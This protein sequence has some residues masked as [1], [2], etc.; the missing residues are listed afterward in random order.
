MSFFCYTLQVNALVV[1][2][3]VSLT[4]LMMELE[5]PLLILLSTTVVLAM[6]TE[7]DMVT[8]NIVSV[9]LSVSDF[10]WD[11]KLAFYVC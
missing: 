1:V 8:L 11:K 4:L 5:L 2:N 3:A 7:E 9:E 6:V 10:L